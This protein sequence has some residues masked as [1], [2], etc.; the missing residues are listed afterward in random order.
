MNRNSLISYAMSFSSFLLDSDIGNR[1]NRIV[2]FGSA[3]KGEYDKESDVDVFVD[4]TVKRAELIKYLNL[5]Y[6]SK[7]NEI[8]ETKGPKNEISLHSGN[9]DTS[10]LKREILG[11]GIQVYGEVGLLPKNMQ[12]YALFVLDFSNFQ[13]KKQVSIWRKLYGYRQKIG[14]K[15][16][17]FKG[18]IEKSGGRKLGKGIVVMP[19]A[20]KYEFS[21]LLKQKRVS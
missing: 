6:S 3:A 10:P 18:L 21:K 20:K 13:R 17:N 11:S 1:I 16:Y 4:T 15:T 12:H 9:M 19:L 5:F 8:W 14:R 7:I 2:I